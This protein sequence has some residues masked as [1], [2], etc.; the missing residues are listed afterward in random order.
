MNRRGQALVLFAL[1]MLLMVLMVTMTLSIGMKTR[2]KIELQTVADAAAYS[3]AVVTARTFNGISI[4]NR[5][6]VGN[7]VAM[8]GV[9]SLISWSSY[10]RASLHGVSQAYDKPLAF[11]AAIVAAQCPIGG[12]QCACATQAVADITET[13]NKFKQEDQKLQQNNWDGLDEK[14]G[15]EARALQIGSIADEQDK[16][17]DQLQEA[18]LEAKLADRIVKEANKG[19]RFGQELVAL[20]SPETQAVVNQELSGGDGCGGPGAVCTPRGASA[21]VIYAT[22]GSRGYSFVTGRGGGADIISKKLKDLMP[23]QDR[24]DLF[25]NR[26]SGY[27]AG[28]DEQ[29][30]SKTASGVE[31]WADDHGDI[32]LTFNR[33][34]A[35]CPPTF[36]GGSKP[37]A[38]VRSTHLVDET[39]RH[40]WTD[41]QDTRPPHRHHTMGECRPEHCPGMWPGYFDYNDNLVADS[42]N[43]W[44]QPK[45]YAVIQRDFSRPEMKPDPWNLMFRFRFTPEN[46]GVTFDNRGIQ[47]SNG[48]D[49][50]KATALSAGIAYYKRA[51]PYWRE[52]PNFLN[53]FWRATLVS[54]QTDAQGKQDIENVLRTAAPFSADVYKALEAKGYS[55]W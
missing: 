36:I 44:G 4:M 14:A 18:L 30:H 7:M 49:I 51:G 19:G 11:Y 17:Y 26:G 34:T 25:T 35:P 52:P 5:A 23:Q 46:D 42:G 50:S 27:F 3:N 29:S 28:E 37:D 24:I 21:H 16:L 10:Y 40:E 41:G 2:E 32:L 15:L 12:P 1:T 33:G 22:M 8:A 9:Q 48:D 47:L 45:L 38:H 39:D 43:N 31:A 6:L 55:A 53:P 54:A 20:W 13:K